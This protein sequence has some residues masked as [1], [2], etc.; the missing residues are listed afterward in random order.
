MSSEFI[1]LVEDDAN[2]RHSI[3]LILQ[4][5]GYIVTTT[6]SISKAMDIIQSGHYQLIVMDNNL[7]EMQKALLTDILVVYPN[8]STVVLTDLSNT[9]KEGKLIRAHYLIKPIAP[10]RL[11]DCVEKIMGERQAFNHGPL[12]TQPIHPGEVQV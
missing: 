2:L 7:P 8:L 4:R 3:A 10:E 5:A 6:D 11:L 9:E 1:L 12:N